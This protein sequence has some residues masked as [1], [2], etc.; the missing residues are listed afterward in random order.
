MVEIW[1]IIVLIAAWMLAIICFMFRAWQWHH[2]PPQE[3]NWDG[4]GIDVTDVMSKVERVRGDFTSA[5]HSRPNE[6]RAQRDLLDAARRG[7]TQSSY[8]RRRAEQTE[9]DTSTQAT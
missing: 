9:H 5:L 8:F 6:N 1:D 2:Q 4:H 3:R 7:V